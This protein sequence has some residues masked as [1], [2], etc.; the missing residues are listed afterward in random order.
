MCILITGGNGNLASILK[1]SLK[2]FTIFAPNRNDLDLTDQKCLDKFFENNKID[3]IIHTAI[4][5]G[6]RTVSDPTE[7]VYQNLLMFENIIRFSDKV[8]S[9]INL[10]SGA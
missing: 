9:I 3:I 7:I 2:N 10:D 6:R 5:G 1:K 8:N 4:K